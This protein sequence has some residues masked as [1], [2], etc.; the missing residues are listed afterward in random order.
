M[1]R[2]PLTQHHPRN[3]PDYWQTLYG[4]LWRR[5]EPLRLHVLIPPSPLQKSHQRS[6]EVM[7]LFNNSLTNIIHKSPSGCKYKVCKDDCMLYIFHAM[8]I[9]IVAPCI[10]KPILFTHQQMHKLLILERFK[11]YTRIHTNIA[12]TCFSLPP[13][14][15]SYKDIILPSVLK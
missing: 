1:R 8:I 5:H 6:T 4:Y 15:G 7:K 2:L 10:L 3:N 9:F 13:S 11:I 12:P 14:S